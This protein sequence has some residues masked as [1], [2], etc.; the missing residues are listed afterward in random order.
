MI[1]LHA[2]NEQR[3]LSRFII[4]QLGEHITFMTLS[5]IQDMKVTG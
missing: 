2:Q 5:E 1:D 3:Y 4:K